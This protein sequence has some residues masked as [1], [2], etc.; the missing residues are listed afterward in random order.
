MVTTVRK[1]RE[2]F[3]SELDQEVKAKLEEFANKIRQLKRVTDAI[4]ENLTKQCEG[5]TT[6]AKTILTDS[7]NDFSRGCA[8]SQ[9]TFQNA[10]DNTLSGFSRNFD[11]KIN[12]IDSCVQR[13]DNFIS[14]FTKLNSEIEQK[15]INYNQGVSQ[16]LKQIQAQYEILS[17]NAAR[18]EKIAFI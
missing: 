3:N 15:L 16:E 5:V 13:L 12:I 8:Q 1:N 9:T 18:R 11:A 6:Q 7:T 17:K 14:V 2:V 10:I 4:C